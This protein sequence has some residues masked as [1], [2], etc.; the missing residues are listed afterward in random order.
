[1]KWTNEANQGLKI[2]NKLVHP[3]WLTIVSFPFMGQPWKI[4]TLSSIERV[5]IEQKTYFWCENTTKKG[6]RDHATSPF[7]VYKISNSKPTL[8]KNSQPAQGSQSVEIFRRWIQHILQNKYNW[9]LRF[10]APNTPNRKRVDGSYPE[11]L[12]GRMCG[13]RDVSIGSCHRS[14]GMGRTGPRPDGGE[15]ERP[16][17]PSVPVSSPPIHPLSQPL[18]RIWQV[19][20]QVPPRGASYVFIWGQPWHHAGKIEKRHPSPS[21]NPITTRVAEVQ[22]WFTPKMKLSRTTKNYNKVLLSGGSFLPGQEPCGYFQW[23]H[24]PLCNLVPRAFPLKNGWGG[25]RPWH[26]LVTCPLVHPKILGVIN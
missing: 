2:R 25:K 19:K 8:L 21:A 6:W 22:M 14:G 11:R 12:P 5:S 18:D 4:I 1:M 10:V 23:L 26:R 9:P 13:G 20:V 3:W 16:L 24:V 17:V 7:L 15:P